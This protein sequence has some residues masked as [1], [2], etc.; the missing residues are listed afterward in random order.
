[1]S[2]LL[3][4]VIRGYRYLLSP[5]WGGQCRFTPTCSEYAMDAIHAHGALRGTWLAMRRV[6]KCHPWHHG[7]FDPAP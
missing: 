6:S 3:L 7:G 1:M 2:H 4:A 5:W